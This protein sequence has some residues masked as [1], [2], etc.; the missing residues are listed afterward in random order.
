MMK[1]EGFDEGFYES[2]RSFLAGKIG[3]D[4]NLGH[5]HRNDVYTLDE[6]VGVKITDIDFCISFVDGLLVINA[7]SEFSNEF[8]RKV[9][10]RLIETLNGMNIQLS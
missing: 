8:Y 4:D 10:L 2:C 6:G 9:E 3:G 7:P 1:L 5:K